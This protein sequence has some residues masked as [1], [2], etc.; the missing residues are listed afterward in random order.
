MQKYFHFV[1]SCDAKRQIP[2]MILDRLAD[3]YLWQ[4]QEAKSGITSIKNRASRIQQLILAEVARRKAQK[5]FEKVVS[6]NLGE[7]AKQI[8]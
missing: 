8:R 6:S 1:I 4:S 2:K 3:E 5:E 7:E